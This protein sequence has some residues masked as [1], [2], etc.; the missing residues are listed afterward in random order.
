M[1]LRRFILILFAAGAAFLL[2]GYREATR[3]PVVR[4]ARIAP[5][6]WPAGQPP[7]RVLLTADIH[8]A[9]PDMPP[10]RVD[11]I[12]RQINALAP[13]LVLIAGDFVSDRR[14]STH[15]YSESEA[16]APLKGPRARLGVVAV[17]G[18]HDHWRNAGAVRTALGAIGVR[19]LD[20]DAA[21][22]GP[23]VIG[24][25]DDAFTGYARP[26]TTLQ[27]MRRLPGAKLVLTHSPDVFPTLPPDAGLVL[28]GH[29]HC[30]QIVLPLIGPLATMSDYGRRYR[31]GLIREG[32]KTL[33]VTAG[34][35]TSIMPIRIGAPP[36]IWLL[37]LG[38]AGTS[39]SPRS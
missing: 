3:T 28:A 2:F 1:T 4:S 33:I 37:R 36:D 6:D 7:L 32:G 15:R 16:I 27:R 25:V 26:I 14:L 31:C 18:N 29:T 35:G 9:G 22:V 13:D 34:V 20:N 24:G 21:R 8:V 38:P 10:S 12:V 5:A 23:L 30:G 39:Q 19:V 17:L 11:R